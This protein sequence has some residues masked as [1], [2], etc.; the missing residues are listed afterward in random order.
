MLASAL[1]D[2]LGQCVGSV[3]TDSLGLLLVLW[4]AVAAAASYYL[5]REG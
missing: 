1:T 3:L 4:I 5:N 2:G